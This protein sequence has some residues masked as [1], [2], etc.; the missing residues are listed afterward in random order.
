MPARQAASRPTTDL[1]TLR[2]SIPS[3]PASPVGYWQDVATSRRLAAAFVAAAGD[4]DPDA[5]TAQTD[6]L[7]SESYSWA[8][9][10][11]DWSLADRGRAFALASR[12][13]SS[14]VLSKVSLQ[15]GDVTLSGSGGRVPITITNGSNK[16][17][18]V[19]VVA[20]SQELAFP[21]G[22]DQKVK[23]LVGRPFVQ[24]TVLKPGES[25]VTVPVDLGQ[26]LAGRMTVSANSAGVELARTS[27]TVRAS[28]LNQLAIVAGIVAVL[29]GLL[30]YVRRR[31]KRYQESTRGSGEETAEAGGDAGDDAPA[32]GVGGEIA[33]Q[34]NTEPGAQ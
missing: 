4:Q 9:P 20:T 3:E 15:T 31:V 5:R 11:G 26:G 6:S 28:F 7:L 8:G 18:K 22:N 27:L 10:M 34:E 24:P 25:F 30:F 12:R 1:A 13:S 33:A 21:T 14:A 19:N 29:L 23:A 17:L 16:E 32:E 2:A